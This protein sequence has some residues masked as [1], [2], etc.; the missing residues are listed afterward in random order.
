[1]SALITQKVNLKAGENI[2]TALLEQLATANSNFSK[3]QNRTKYLEDLKNIFQLSGDP[4]VTT[5]SNLFLGGFLEGEGSMNISCKRLTTAKFGVILDPEFSITQHVNG[6]S[7]LYLALL[8]LQ[9][10]R[11]SHK[12]GSNATMVFKIDNRRTLEEKV[13]PFY[14][15]YVVPYGSDEKVRRLAKFKAFLDLYNQDA[16][17]K[18]SSFVTKLLPIWDSMRKQSGQSNQT[19]ADLQSAQDYVKNFALNKV[20]GHAGSAPTMQAQ[21]QQNKTP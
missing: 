12:S 14:N 17:T 9:A 20:P 2:P 18:L 5:E 11:I 6:F 4:M 19:F 21:T 15:D 3:S 13:L 1:M 10:G 16:H 8:T 7:V